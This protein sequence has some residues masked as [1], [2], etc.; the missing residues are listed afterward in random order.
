MD[1]GLKGKKAL[2]CGAS[3]GIGKA[4][5]HALCEEG[6][7]LFL[8]SRG[9]EALGK[10]Q[11]ELSRISQG[12][13]MSKALDLSDIN[14]RNEL[15]ETVQKEFGNPDILVHN[16][17]GP[18]PSTT[19]NTSISDWQTGFD[20]L[21][22]S[23]A[24]LNEMFLPPMKEAMWGRILTVTSLSVLEPIKTLAVSNAIRSATTSMLKALSD[25]VAPFNITVNCVAPGAIKTDRLEQL[26]EARI[27][28]TGQ[29]REEYE[30]EYLA[31]IPAG[32]LGR[33][34]EFGA[35]AAF[36]CSDKASYITG[37]TIAIDGGK[38]RSTY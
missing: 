33:P 24:H 12:K 34:E 8:C 5:A 29:S 38:R 7:S 14:S 21:F 1:L 15:I 31:A 28:S 32:R 26:M 37:S 19:T 10:T 6:A 17:G 3:K 16:V 11:Q 30:K 4:I 25:E 20:Q 18:K 2:V 27:K 23:V 9:L 22:Q 13:V 35:V 36:L